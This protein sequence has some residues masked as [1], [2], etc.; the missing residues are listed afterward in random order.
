MSP[1]RNGSARQRCPALGAS[2]HLMPI[3]G[4]GL[5]GLAG[6]A[7]SLAPS[8]TPFPAVVHAEEREAA[9][10]ATAASPGPGSSLVPVPGPRAAP[11]R[12]PSGAR[13]ENRLDAP[14]GPW[15]LGAPATSP[16][17]GWV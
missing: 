12:G 1:L 9:V 15:S 10:E 13:L 2:G 17:R 5:S 14:P 4:H 3:E 8:L 7:P 6:P 11:V 16:P